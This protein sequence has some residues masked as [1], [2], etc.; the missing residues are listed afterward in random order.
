[1]SW[2]VELSQ[3]IP[4]S[5]TTRKTCPKELLCYASSKYLYCTVP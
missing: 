4:W 1:V 2:Y 5:K 3:N